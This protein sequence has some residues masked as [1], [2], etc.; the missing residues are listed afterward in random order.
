MLTSVLCAQS[1]LIVD[2]ALFLVFLLRPV[3]FLFLRYFVSSMCHIVYLS[4]HTYTCVLQ[5]LFDY[6]P[7]SSVVE[8]MWHFDRISFSMHFS[9]PNLFS[10]WIQFIFSFSVSNRSF[11]FCCQWI[12]IYNCV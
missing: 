7:F 9:S 8:Y 10:T 5:P 1:I 12:G 4:S 6:I 11:L 3:S 2:I